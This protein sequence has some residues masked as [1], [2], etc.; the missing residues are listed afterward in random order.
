MCIRDRNEGVLDH[1]LPFLAVEQ[2]AKAKI[3]VG[4]HAIHLLLEQIEQHPVS[5][6][7]A[8]KTTNARQKNG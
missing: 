2:S 8:L 1:T 4:Q 6:W 3:K 5:H 7:G